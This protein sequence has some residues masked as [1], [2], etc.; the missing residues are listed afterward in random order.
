MSLGVDKLKGWCFKLA[1][2]PEGALSRLV[3][4]EGGLYLDVSLGKVR[5]GAPC[6]LH[7]IML[8]T[9]AAHSANFAPN[10]SNVE[11]PQDPP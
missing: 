1:W 3:S 4:F 11:L 5:C 9:L 10:S 6:S 8:K 7:F 2:Y